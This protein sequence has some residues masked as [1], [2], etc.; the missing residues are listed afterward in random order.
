[1]Q[2]QKWLLLQRGIIVLLFTQPEGAEGAALVLDMV[3]KTYHTNYVCF[4]TID[5]LRLSKHI[6]HPLIV[7]V[8]CLSCLAQVL[9][10]N[11]SH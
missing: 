5:L 2:L 9:G 3:R 1:M 8:A 4:K 10:V 6:L 11:Y 7:F